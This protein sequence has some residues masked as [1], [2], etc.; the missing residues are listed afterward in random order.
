MTFFV[1]AKIFK[2]ATPGV[3]WALFGDDATGRIPIA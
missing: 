2:Y 3:M 1:V